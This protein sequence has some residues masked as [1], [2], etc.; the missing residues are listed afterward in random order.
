MLARRPALELLSAGSSNG[1]TCGGA[2]LLPTQAEGI[3]AVTIDPLHPDRIFI[4][5]Y[6]VGTLRSEDGGRTFRTVNAGLPPEPAVQLEA[7]DT[8]AFAVYGR[9]H[10]YTLYGSRDG[11]ERWSL[12]GGGGQPPMGEVYDV[13]VTADGTAVLAGANGGLW[14]AR[15]D[16]EPLE[17]K[18]VIPG[19]SVVLIETASEDPEQYYLATWEKE[20]REGRLLR[21]RFGGEPQE[22]LSGFK[23]QP[24][25]IAVNPVPAAEP[26]AFLLLF[27]GDVWVPGQSGARV[28]SRYPRWSIQSRAFSARGVDGNGARTTGRHLMVGKP[29]R[30]VHIRA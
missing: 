10:N 26:A 18:N 8:Q 9:K 21:W 12:I 2:E 13:R 19:E 7:H 27:N 16:T 3:V 30:S 11:G 29:K 1:P 14:M 6:E 25:G 15:L 20:A 5:V 23:K 28:I 24:M 17:W 4:S 22:L